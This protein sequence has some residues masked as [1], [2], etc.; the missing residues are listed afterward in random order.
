MSRLTRLDTGRQPDSTPA[1]IRELMQKT[2]DLDS[3]DLHLSP[4]S[5][6]LLRIDGDLEMLKLPRLRGSD[7]AAMIHPILT[8]KQLQVLADNRSLDVAYTYQTDVRFRINVFHQRGMI[9]AVLRRLPSLTLGI[10]SL[11]LPP[12]VLSL[13]MVRDGL[14]LVTGPTGSGKSTTLAAV[15]DLIN[16]QQACHIITI[17]DPIEFVHTNASALVTQRELNTDV[18]SFDQ[19]L[20]DSLREDPDVI[21]VGE[22]RDLDTMRTAIMA[23]ETGHLVFSTLHSR[24]A[25]S[26]LIRM[27]NVFPVG[28]QAQIR[29]QLSGV[30]KAV[31]SQR[32]LKNMAGSGRCPAVE[33]MKVTPAIANLI[34]NGKV[35]QVYS[36]IETGE[37]DG[38]QTME[39]ALAKLYADGK[40]D[41]EI[42]LKMAKTESLITPR[43]DRIDG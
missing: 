22:M 9:S 6:P 36:L 32:L 11:G 40:I 12:S 15:I 4:G 10:E 18:A 3:S 24:D 23:A 29:Q 14:V 25:V 39:C 41:R 43:L 13:T 33:V 5:P 7:I 1:T 31:V 35:E 34:R 30:L 16:K 2:L 21:L 8:E 28:E 20:R 17:E 38:M 37:K 27:I 26:S 19:A 42:A